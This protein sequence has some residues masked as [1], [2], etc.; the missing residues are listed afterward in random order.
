MRRGTSAAWPKL[1]ARVLRRAG[2]VC[3]VCHARPAVDVDHVLAVALGGTDAEDNLRALCGWCHRKKTRSDV[4]EFHARRPTA[5]RPV[6][7]HPG[8]LK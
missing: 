5:K 7:R 1:R 6:E 4:R 2:N 3:E 8:A